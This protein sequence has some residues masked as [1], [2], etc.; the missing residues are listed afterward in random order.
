MFVPEV[1]VMSGVNDR[2]ADVVNV[3]TSHPKT[4]SSY[5]F[6]Y[7]HPYVISESSGIHS[8]SKYTSPVYKL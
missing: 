6:V 8:G 5:I 4:D 2:P 7:S 1:G 3:L